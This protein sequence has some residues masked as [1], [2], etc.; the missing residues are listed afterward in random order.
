M[1][2][3]AT[4]SFVLLIKWSSYNYAQ[5]LGITYHILESKSTIMVSLTES[6]RLGLNFLL[7]QAKVSLQ[8]H[9]LLNCSNL[10]WK[11]PTNVSIVLQD[12]DKNHFEMKVQTHL[13][14][15]L[16]EEDQLLFSACNNKAASPLK[17]ADRQDYIAIDRYSMQS[18]L[19]NSTCNKP[20]KNKN[21]KKPPTTSL[22]C[23]Q[24]HPLNFKW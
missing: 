9:S 13:K 1:C 17:Q 21:H 3:W 2:C 7:A 24:C 11:L 19:R 20:Q 10:L 8:V 15:Q 18:S 6:K 12:E 22:Y 16:V 4:E 5:I 14:L 23:Q